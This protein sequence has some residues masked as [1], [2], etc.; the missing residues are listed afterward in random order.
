MGENFKGALLITP[1]HIINTSN[2]SSAGRY[3][4]L[5]RG[6]RGALD[7]RLEE[8]GVRNHEAP[9]P[10]GKTK[11]MYFQTFLNIGTM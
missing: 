9:F 5:T 10:D 7:C 6:N 11:T 2:P 1:H 8:M 3:A 4:V